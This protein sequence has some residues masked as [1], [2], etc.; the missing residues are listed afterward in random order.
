[1]INELIVRQFAEDN[2]KHIQERGSQLFADCPFCGKKHNH[3]NVSLETGKFNCYRCGK[4]GSFSRLTKQVLGWKTDTK[5]L[6][7]NYSSNITLATL[8]N[9]YNN[10]VSYGEL[11][12]DWQEGTISIFDSKLICRRALE[13]LETRNLTRNQ[14]KELQFR[15]GIE[16]RYKNMLVLP[17]YFDNEIVNLVA[18]Q[19][20][21]YPAKS[22]YLYPHKNEAVMEVSELVYN[23]DDAKDW[24]WVILC[25]GVFDVIALKNKGWPVVGLLGKDISNEQVLLVSSTWNSV[26]V[27]L[28]GGFQKDAVKIARNLEG[29][30]DN[31]GIAII[32]GTEDPSENVEKAIEA[33]KNAKV[34]EY[35]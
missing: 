30:T 19:I 17:I 15:V 10:D 13:Y 27:L 8:E 5:Q 34:L 22:R 16:G 33:V 4:G 31:I 3:F 7:E 23:Y 25:E 26:V 1:M 21:E 18:R 14:I 29:L 35:F 9:I 24:E 12:F 28:D 32:E 2:L 6:I 20:P 11:F